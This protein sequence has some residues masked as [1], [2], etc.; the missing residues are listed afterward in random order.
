MTKEF[1]KYAGPALE[2]RMGKR[3][4]VAK[5]AVYRADGGVILQGESGRNMENIGRSVRITLDEWDNRPR[6]EYDHKVESKWALERC[7]FTFSY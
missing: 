6:D 2:C 3:H 4:A 5:V 1:I 7:G